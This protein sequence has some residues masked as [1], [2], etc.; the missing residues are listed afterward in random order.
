M[1]ERKYGCKIVD[2]LTIGETTV[3]WAKAYQKA[4]SDR[5]STITN[6][7]LDGLQ[8]RISDAFINI[9]GINNKQHII[10]ATR[11]LYSIYKPARTDLVDFYKQIKFDLRNNPERLQ[12]VLALFSFNSLYPSIRRGDQE[13]VI[14]L[15]NS[16]KANLVPDLKAELIALG[17]DENLINRLFTYADTLKN[18]NVTQELAKIESKQYTQQDVAALN[19]IY[20]HII[21]INSIAQRANIDKSA[22]SNFSFAGMLK[23]LNH[24]TSTTTTTTTTTTSSTTTTTTDDSATDTTT[25]TV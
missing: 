24:Q 19:D 2:L 23:R 8:N 21:F 7:F 14:Q 20:D 1:E 5:R 22:K 25:T 16:I 11:V 12:Q 9:L 13:A 18:A 10:N 15:L 6:V 4:L 17:T 3:L